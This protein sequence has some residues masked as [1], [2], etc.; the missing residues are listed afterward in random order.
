[1]YKFRSYFAAFST[2]LTLAACGGGDGVSSSTETTPVVEAQMISSAKTVP[3]AVL[4]E[5]GTGL[6]PVA[7]G[8]VVLQSSHPEVNK[9]QVGDVLFVPPV[10][11]KGLGTSFVGKVS[12]VSSADGKTQV[13][14][15][16]ANVEDAYTSLKWDIDTAKTGASVVGVISPPK[17]KVSFSS[18]SNIS[19]QT[20]LV[21]KDELSVKGSA[22]EGSIKMEHELLYKGKSVVLFAEVDLSGVTVRSRGDYDVSNIG[23]DNGWVEFT[24]VVKGDLGAKIGLRAPDLVEVPT[25]ADLVASQDVWADLKWSGSD[26]YKLEGLEGDDKKGRIPLGGVVLTPCPTGVCPLK[27]TGNLGNNTVHLFSI[28]PTA[29]LWVYMDMSGKISVSGEVGARLNGYHFEQGYEFKAVNLTLST[30]RI[31]VATPSALEI[32]GNATLDVE[33]RFGVSVGADILVGGIRPV[34]VNTFVGAQHT[35]KL[36]GELSYAIVPPNG[37]AGYGCVES[38]IWA[39]VELSAQFRMKAEVPVDLYFKRFELGGVIERS[40]SGKVL[41]IMAEKDLGS[42]CLVSGPFSI[43]AAVKGSD[44]EVKA[45]ALIDIDFSSGYNNEN[46][47]KFTDSWRIVAE[48]ADCEAK[49]FD[50]IYKGDEIFKPYYSISL[51]VGRK[52]VIRLQAKSDTD[53]DWVI[54]EA[55]TSVDVGDRPSADFVVE[56][57]M[58][59]CRD[60]NLTATGVASEGRSIQSYQ[61]KVRSAGLSSFLDYEGR[62]VSSVVLPVCGLTQIMLT[63]IDSAGLVT[64]V[65]RTI[66]TELM[67]PKVTEITPLSAVLNQLT[68]IKISGQ[69][70]PLTSVLSIADATCQTPTNRTATGFTVVCTPGGAAG[71]KVVTVK[72]DTEANGGGVIDA[73]KTV[74]VQAI[75]IPTPALSIRFDQ[76]SLASLGGVT[77]A[78]SVSYISGKDGR[79]AAKFSG[80]AA[81]GHIKINNRESLKFVDGATFDMWVY[82]DS[83]TGMDG[84]GRT[85]S[86]GAYAMAFVAKSHDRSGGVMLANSLT[87]PDGSL[88]H[89]GIGNWDSCKHL[90]STPVPLGTWARVTY[91]FSSTSG[92]Y[93]YLNKNLTWNCPGDRPNFGI[94]NTQDMYIG[95]FSDSWYPFSGA[96]QDLNVYSKALSPAQV[97]ALQ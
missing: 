18:N 52:Y 46:V 63:V 91:V 96:I 49:V 2:A 6:T 42:S 44:P 28:A 10:S 92:T 24:A 58:A 31:A 30:K 26:A 32:Y 41:D 83:M 84:W 50:V 27:F 81:P 20:G 9:Y 86:D 74:I 13:N 35:G 56:S 78:G 3:D 53:A 77:S 17:A 93:A 22:L 29:I 67:A 38:K 54:R 48:C 34:A 82:M 64:A 21:I 89:A 97:S 4:A 79:P 15:I 5:S 69:N 73:S 8:G 33:Q 51:P 57:N 72:T 16:P 45:N 40:Y 62:S 61:W 76:T 87:N 36:E 59:D 60:L 14:L 25:L 65:S 23:S 37:W 66:D 88:W 1:M 94:M 85:V 70:L 7:S 68:T 55:F 11:G 75:D 95:K 39:G 80:V 90:S 12:G 19:T 71:S 47:R 43:A